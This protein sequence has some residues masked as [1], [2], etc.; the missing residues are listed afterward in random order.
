MKYLLSVAA[1]LAAFTLSGCI[2]D[3]SGD[4]N[5]DYSVTETSYG[6]GDYLICNDSECQVSNNDEPTD[7]EVGEFNADYTQTEC[8][9]AGFFYCTIDNICIDAATDVGTCPDGDGATIQ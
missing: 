2:P 1:L 7:V 5:N 4:T 8:I 3:V 6:D 9:A